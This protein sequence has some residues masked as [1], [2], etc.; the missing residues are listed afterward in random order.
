MDKY[1]LSNKRP[2]S[3]DANIVEEEMVTPPVDISQ[4]ASSGPQRPI[5][6]KYPQRVWGSKSSDQQ[7]NRSFTSSWYDS[8]TWI[9]YSETQDRVYC[10]AC[11][12]FRQNLCGHTEPAFTHN[13][14]I[15]WKKAT[16]TFKA[17]EA[18][19]SHKHA[20]QAWAERKLQQQN[21]SHILKR[22]D[23][24][25]STMVQENRKYI[26]A[27]IDSLLYTS[28]Q[29]I[30]QR[31]HREDEDSDNRGNFLELLRLL[32]KYDDVVKRKLQDL[33]RNAK[34]THHNI[35]NE[36]INIMANMI[37]SEISDEVKVS[38][39]FA[40]LVDETKDVSKT[41]QISVVVRYM[42]QGKI[43]E[44]FLG[45]TA[46]EGLN[47]PALLVKIKET[48]SQCN[49]DKQD[50][51]GQCYDGA[52]VMSGCNNGVQQLFR[53]EVPGA[54]YVHCYAHRLNLALV[55]CVRGVQSVAEFFVALQML[56]KFFATSVVHDL[57]I[58]NQTELGVAQPIELK[59]LSET[60]WA[61]QDAACHAVR[62]TLPAICVTLLDVMESDNAD[63]V[64]EATAIYS[65]FKRTF[66]VHLAMMGVLLNLTKLLSDMLQSPQLD[67]AS[68]INLV[69]TVEDDLAD[70]RGEAAWEKIWKESIDLAE[71][72]DIDLHEAPVRRRRQP[73]RLEGFS[74][75][76]PIG[77]RPKLVTQ[78]DYCTQVYYPV[79]DRLKAE[80]ENRFSN[81]AC[82]VL[83][84]VAA[85]NPKDDTF[86][87]DAPIVGMA[88]HYGVQAGN[89]PAELTLVR[90]LVRRRADS[91][92][93]VTTPLE[94]SNMLKPYCDAFTDVYQMLCI[95]VTMPV[96]SASCERS[97]SC[98]KLIKTYL[99]N[100]SGHARTS[101][102]GVISINSKRAKSLIMDSVID[103][104]ARNHN[105]RRIILF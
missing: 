103:A 96:S 6:R 37:R 59:R 10:F 53:R 105:N 66:V 91:G 20:M 40:L 104:F 25:H 77:N 15:N 2:R 44:S 54:V 27:V 42:Y 36:I 18:S 72:C 34:Y 7:H 55:D 4:D 73:R 51:I 47:A 61:C 100:S 32:T 41:E 9:E 93:P 26:E 81:D 89:I 95:S 102:L 50:C 19:P 3:D 14:Y 97:F 29:N 45:Y 58:A 21:G 62:E 33:P 30:A 64:T 31:G 57:F 49:I 67:L 38:K 85:L 70:R 99:R 98:L 69:Q 65:L 83:T 17:H 82:R 87:D 74:V 78:S 39:H 94:F 79:I 86:L 92:Q 35:Q 28:C 13:G 71:A 80:L 8:H 56:Y 76:A 16:T 60:R 84:G 23:D 68:A 5:L 11:R 48:L 63:R 88:Q 1:L 52:S 46:A 101:D 75:E 22:L 90:R 12:H 43:Y 24:G